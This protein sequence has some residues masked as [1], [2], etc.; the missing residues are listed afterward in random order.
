M[1]DKKTWRSVTVGDA[2]E[3]VEDTTLVE[4]G[5]Y[6]VTIVSWYYLTRSLNRYI[7]KKFRK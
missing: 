3:A 5:I 4:V 7:D 6:A 1:P 2:K